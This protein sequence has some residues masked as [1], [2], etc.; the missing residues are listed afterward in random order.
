[1]TM[2]PR[3][4]E[5]LRENEVLL[6]IGVHKTGTTAIQG[7]LAQA[8]SELA[9]QGVLYPGKLPSQFRAAMSIVNPAEEDSDDAV[10]IPQQRWN[11][12]VKQVAK[13]DGTVVISSEV[14]CEADDDTARRI[15]TEL[16]DRPIAVLIGVRP[17]W[18]QLAS[19]WQQYVKS[20]LTT[21]YH[22]WLD[23]TF[24]GMSPTPSFWTRNDLPA[25]VKRWSHA[26]GVSRVGVFVIDTDDR[27]AIFGFF[28]ELIGLNS[29]TLRANPDHPSNPS[30][31]AEQAEIIRRV[32]V[33]V[34]GKLDYRTYRRRIRRGAVTEF[35]ADVSGPA[36]STPQWALDA[37]VD[38]MSAQLAA[39]E[40]A[41]FDR[42][43]DLSSLTSTPPPAGPEPTLD[44]QRIRQSVSAICAAVLE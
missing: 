28:D 35:L 8:R 1:M 39:V 34:A 20:T 17:L 3:E 13:A 14:F 22:T 33:A 27:N 30:L 31:N 23:E 10:A 21:P 41:S 12:L 25:L 16:T 36:I 18:Q 24:H 26:P 15:T 38:T 9:A 6:H 43:N 29:G 37:A 42:L 5:W 32:N 7:A 40:H 2:R 4:T 19:S 11:T 44:E